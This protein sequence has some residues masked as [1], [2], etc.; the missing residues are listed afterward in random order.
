MGLNTHY[1][2]TNR[3]I[4]KIAQI[5]LGFVISAFLCG[6]WYGGEKCF[7]N[8]KLS[9]VSGLNFVLLVINIVLVILNFVELGMWKLER[10]YSI[11]GAVLFLVAA[12]IFLWYMI[13]DNDSS[14]W[15]IAT[16]VMVFV[17]FL[18][19]LWDVKILQGE[20]PN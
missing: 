5:I 15:R 4:I 14:G 16:L 9:F 18:L 12:A 10:I 17:Q 1:F 13:Q 19:F 11:I 2:G 8:G 6:A 3:G 7:G 20:S